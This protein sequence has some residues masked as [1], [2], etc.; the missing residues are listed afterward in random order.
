MWLVNPHSEKWTLKLPKHYGNGQDTGILI[1]PEP[2]LN[3]GISIQPKKEE[4]GASLG[5]KMELRLP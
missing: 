3:T 2:G 4:I 5:G 1:S